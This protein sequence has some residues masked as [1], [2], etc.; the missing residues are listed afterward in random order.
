MLNGFRDKDIRYA[1]I[2]G[3][4][5]GVLGVPR[6]TMDLDF[7]VHREDLPALEAL[8]AAL[9]YSRRFHSENVSQYE[10]KDAAWGSVDFLHAFRKTAIS[11]LGRAMERPVFAGTAVVRVLRPEDVIGLKVQSMANDPDRRTKDAADIESLAR[12]DENVAR[13]LAQ[14]EVKKVIYVPDKLLNFVVK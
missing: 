10:N 3:F 12:Q 9:G 14:G 8:M 13:Y 1:A 2:G 11:M 7:L 4:A 5:L 6:A